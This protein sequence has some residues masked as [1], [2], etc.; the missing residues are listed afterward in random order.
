[1]CGVVF[2]GDLFGC[3]ALVL[4]GCG[5]FSWLFVCWVVGLTGLGLG[6]L[7]EVCESLVGIAY[8]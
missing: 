6:C 7:V 3:F 5:W 1:M 4:V 2:C 8:L